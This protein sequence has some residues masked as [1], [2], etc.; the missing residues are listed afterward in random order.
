[1]A[2]ETVGLPEKVHMKITD[3][4]FDMGEVIGDV[5]LILKDAGGP[6]VI[7]MMAM[8]DIFSCFKEWIVWSGGPSMTP[9][10]YLGGDQIAA[11]RILLKEGGDIGKTASRIAPIRDH[12]IDPDM[13]KL[14]MNIIAR[15]AEQVNRG[16]VSRA[17]ILSTD[18]ARVHILHYVADVAYEMMK[19][20]K[21]I[22][23]T[24]HYLEKEWMEMVERNYSKFLSDSEG[25]E[26]VVKVKKVTNLGRLAPPK[27]DKISFWAIDING[28]VEVTVNGKT[29][30][31]NGVAHEILP[32]VVLES[33]NVSDDLIRNTGYALLLLSNAS[34]A[35]STITN[36]TIPTA[37]AVLLR[38]MSPKAAIREVLKG[39]YLTAA[40]PGT[41]DKAVEV[42]KHA[43]RIYGELQKIRQKQINE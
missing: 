21:S 36:I 10:S 37:I 33:E 18:A 40:L 11:M 4:E 20:G 42:A 31:L 22:T 32:R 1:V 29:S 14:G 17:L 23:D 8:V 16:P 38:D 43:R 25:K 6:S 9:L 28:D 30:F 24:V 2:V 39:A 13:A 7:G 3:E 34:Y 27:K 35:S 12:K 5:A 26:I 19:E 41:K 15:K